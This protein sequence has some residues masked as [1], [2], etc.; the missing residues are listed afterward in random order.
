MRGVSASPEV[1][2][3]L[4]AEAAVFLARD[5]GSDGFFDRFAQAV[6]GDTRTASLAP[7]RAHAARAMPGCVA[8]SLEP[9]DLRVQ[10][11]SSG[12]SLTACALPGRAGCVAA[13]V[14]L[15]DVGPPPA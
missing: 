8:F 4:L 6:S 15:G 3:G 5:R 7:D 12:A 1:T 14:R 2:E 10:N 9:G 13:A 11:T